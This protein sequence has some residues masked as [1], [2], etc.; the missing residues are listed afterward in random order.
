LQPSTKV[1]ARHSLLD[2]SLQS[3]FLPT[4]QSNRYSVEFKLLE[5]QVDT[6]CHI[7]QRKRLK[8]NANN[9]KRCAP[10]ITHTANPFPAQFSYYQ[11]MKRRG[12]SFV[13]M[14]NP[15]QMADAFHLF[16]NKT[17]KRK[18]HE[19]NHQAHKMNITGKLGYDQWV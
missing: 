1:K 3:K 6:L 15:K 16:P 17:K 14:P 9:K 8:K 18:Q 7:W 5:K 19:K 2:Y 12:S 11:R 4:G 10:A 13:A